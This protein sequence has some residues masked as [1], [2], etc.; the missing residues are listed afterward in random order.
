MRNAILVNNLKIWIIGWCI[1]R[2]FNCLAVMVY[3]NDTVHSILKLSLGADWL[4]AAWA[5]PGFSSIWSGGEYFYSPWWD[6]SPSQITAPQ[7]ARFPQ[8][9]A[10]THLYSWVERG[11]VRV[12]SCP[13]TQHCVSG[14]ASARTQLVRYGD[15]RT[16]HEV[17]HCFLYKITPLI[18]LINLTVLVEMETDTICQITAISDILQEAISCWGTERRHCKFALHVLGFLPL[19]WITQCFKVE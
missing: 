3:F 8:Q 9:F 6:A 14:N 10:G 5:Y 2:V 4:I 7:F 11:T 18:W 1:S 19:Q 17:R 13:R 12:V 15:E 16:N